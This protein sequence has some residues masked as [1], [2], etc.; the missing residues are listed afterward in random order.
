MKLVARACVRARAA[1]RSLAI[2]QCALAA[3]VKTCFRVR[4]A[5]NQFVAAR[6]QAATH[7]I[8]D[9]PPQ[10]R[11]IARRRARRVRAL[12]VAR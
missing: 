3:G 8:A 6:L 4:A 5:S 12:D 10:S 11:W 7:A 9:R 1:R 2:R